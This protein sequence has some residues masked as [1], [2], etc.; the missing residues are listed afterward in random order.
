M[1][2]V[3]AIARAVI[4]GAVGGALS[5]ALITIISEHGYVP[6]ASVAAIFGSLFGIV[7]FPVCYF[8]IVRDVPMWLVIVCAIPATIAG[9]IGFISY[10]GNRDVPSGSFLFDFFGGGFGG[11]LLT[12]V[13]LRIVYST[14]RSRFISTAPKK[15]I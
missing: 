10:L 14:K 7:A 6:V 4:A 1:K 3:K 11:L 12:C 15:P 13:V 5:G 8:A 2:T 9:E